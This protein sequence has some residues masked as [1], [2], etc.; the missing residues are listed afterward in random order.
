MECSSSFLAD[1]LRMEWPGQP[2]IRR[3][4]DGRAACDGDARPAGCVR[5]ALE[6][7]CSFAFEPSTAI[8]I[9]DLLITFFDDSTG[10][11]PSTVWTATPCDRS[12][13]VGQERFS[14]TSSSC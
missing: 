12:M 3:K 7:S 9:G 13:V 4:L 11:N 6:R 5:A 14:Q 1:R 8:N 2:N 10:A